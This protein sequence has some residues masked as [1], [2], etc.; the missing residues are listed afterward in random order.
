MTASI[1]IFP[2]SQQQLQR[3]RP[4]ASLATARLRNGFLKIKKDEPLETAKKRPTYVARPVF[5]IT[6]DQFNFQIVLSPTLCV[7]HAPILEKNFFILKP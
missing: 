6:T 2:N 5:L 4:L 1:P 3:I 7:I